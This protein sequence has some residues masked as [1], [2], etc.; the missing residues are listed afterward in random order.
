MAS[1]IPIKVTRKPSIWHLGENNW[2]CVSGY[3][4]RKWLIFQE[5]KMFVGYGATEFAAFKDWQ[6]NPY[7]KEGAQYIFDE[8]TKTP[9]HR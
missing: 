9:I 6:N 3:V 2:Q 1:V 5:Q 7:N 4:R 8:G